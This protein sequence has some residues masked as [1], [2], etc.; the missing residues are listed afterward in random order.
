MNEYYYTTYTLNFVITRYRLP[1]LAVVHVNYCL[2]FS[3]M[4][5]D[6]LKAY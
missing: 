4:Y 2:D 3:I 1:Y 5:N 6:V